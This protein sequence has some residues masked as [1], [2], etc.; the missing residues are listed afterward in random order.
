MGGGGG[1]FAVKD[2]LKLSARPAT[3]SKSA[4]VKPVNTKPASVPKTVT[5]AAPQPGAASST[6]PQSSAAQ[7]GAAA[8]RIKVPAGSDAEAAWN[9]YL[10]A[11]EESPAA[12]RETVRQL[13]LEKKYD[14]VVA[15][16]MAALKNKQQQPWMYEAMGLAMQA[17]GRSLEDIDRTLMSAVDFVQ[18][19]DHMMYLAEY[20]AGVGLEKRALQLFHQ[21]ATA[22]PA[23]P[24]P[25]VHAL[26]IAKKLDDIDAIQWS[27]VGILGLAWNEEEAPIWTEAYNVAAA[28]LD[29]LRSE[30]R[31][32][33]A[34]EYQ[35]KLDECM[36]RD[37]VVKITWTGEADLDLLVEEPTGTVASA[38]NRRT[39]SGGVLLGD[40][41]R[42]LD[43]KS[44]VTASESYVCP[45]GFDGVYRALVR[46]VWG[47]L[48]TG[49]VTVDIYTHYLSKSE[50]HIHKQ[51]PLTDDEALIIFDLKDGRRTEPLAKQQLANAVA[52]QVHVGQ[53]VLAQQLAAAANPGSLAAFLNSRGVGPAM[54]GQA[55]MPFFMRGAVGY[56][57]VIT[58]LPS[59]A[60]MSVAPAVVSHD[61]RYVR[62]SP[63]PFFSGIAQVNTFNYVTGSSGTSN[64]SS[65]G[66][67]G[68]FGGGSGLSGSGTGGF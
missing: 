20:L 2:D 51:I 42:S 47:K 56:Q 38:R 57:P 53:Q 15:L 60:N 41:S 8:K 6:A 10:A 36:I 48:T 29:R 30:N 59:G 1:M 21:V 46:R 17:A 23:A 12:V 4:D 18:G 63:V 26:R 49:K 34:D 32:S 33:E 24:Q 68:S 9:D 22:E 25:Y 5:P 67:G 54:G 58:V 40:A 52:K 13:T 64:G 39:T 61:R 19:T 28:T 14:Q 45:V 3:D 55:F 27:T 31:K 65:G 66:S 43:R 62:V 50:S 16:I 44:N 35:R 7:P 37:I 11:N